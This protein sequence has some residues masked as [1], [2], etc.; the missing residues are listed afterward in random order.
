L[1]IPKLVGIGDFGLSVA[2]TAHY[3]EGT[4]NVLPGVLDAGNCFG[5][6]G[7]LT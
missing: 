4:A 7:Y 5:V 1:F 6:R 3:D 2:I